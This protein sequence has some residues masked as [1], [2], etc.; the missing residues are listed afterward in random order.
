MKKFIANLRTPTKFIE[1]FEQFHQTVVTLIITGASGLVCV[2]TNIPL[3]Q[4]GA[5]VTL[6]LSSV[7]PNIVNAAT[8]E[9]YPTA[10]R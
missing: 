3:L 4:N 1:H 7:A 10:L 5:F 6:M 2:L 9:V 8:V